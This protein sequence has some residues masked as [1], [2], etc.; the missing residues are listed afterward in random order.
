MLVRWFN[1]ILFGNA[2]YGDSNSFREIKFQ[3]ASKWK[4]E[5]TMIARFL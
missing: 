2:G 5:I 4:M 1:P 3:S